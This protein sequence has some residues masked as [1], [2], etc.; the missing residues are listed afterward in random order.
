MRIKLTLAYDGAKF[1]GW[2]IQPGQCTVQGEL[3]RALAILFASESKKQGGADPSDPIH[4]T[5]SGRTDAGVHAVAQVA[6]FSWPDTVPLD[7]GYLKR[8]LNG[9]TRR[10]VS[11]LAAEVVEDSFSARHAAHI[12]CYRYD[13]LLR[14]AAPTYED[15]L[16][17]WIRPAVDVPRMKEAAALFVG[18]HDFS[19]FQAADGCAATT[20]RSIE[21]SA[22]EAGD[23]SLLHYRI[24]G[25]GFLKHM[26]RSIA[27]TLYE[28]GAGKRTLS[29]VEKLL[30]GGARD[31]IGQTAPACGLFLESVRY[32]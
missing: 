19:A 16:V 2:Q 15:G 20:I 11:V 22:L 7:C 9:I 8:S 31:D 1:S 27:G 25:K 28:V 30:S 10:G 24:M 26:V 29:S 18:T 4:V 13:F 17:W 23:N 5:G 3:E 6:S 32:L 14:D 12:K 21:S